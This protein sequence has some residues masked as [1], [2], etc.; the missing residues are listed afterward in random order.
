[1]S[2]L[3]FH[4][5]YYREGGKTHLEGVSFAIEPGERLVAF[6]RSGSG[7]HFLLQLAAGVLSPTKG[8]VESPVQGGEALPVGWIPNEGGLLNNLTLVQN[9]ALPLVYHGLLDRSGAER[10]ARDLLAGWGL[11][12]EGERRPAAVGISAQRMAQL[13]RAKLVRPSV[14]LLADPLED[15]DA[16]TARR[17]RRVLEELLSGGGRGCLVTTGDLASYLDW[18]TRFLFLRGATL[19]IFKGKESLLS[20]ADAEVREF[21]E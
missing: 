8:R 12:N 11:G 1:M 2:L 18:G 4:E 19:S 15:V 17:V 14:F 13:A 20:S 21:L 7:K 16:A 6:G 3:S 10:A 9:V 5:V